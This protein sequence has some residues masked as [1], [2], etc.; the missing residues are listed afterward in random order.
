MLSK[1]DDAVFEA[2][3][4]EALAAYD[5]VIGHDLSDLLG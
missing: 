3:A 4:A 2:L 1:H 5:R